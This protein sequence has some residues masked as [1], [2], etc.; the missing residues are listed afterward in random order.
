MNEYIKMNERRLQE[1]MKGLIMKGLIMMINLIRG[2]RFGLGLEPLAEPASLTA[3][4]PERTR[5]QHGGVG[6]RK[7]DTNKRH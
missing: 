5:R 7:S 4:S 3:L 1:H 2:V 6:F